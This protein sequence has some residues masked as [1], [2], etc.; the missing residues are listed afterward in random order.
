MNV[1]DIRIQVNAYRIDD[2]MERARVTLSRCQIPADIDT[3]QVRNIIQSLDSLFANLRMAYAKFKSYKAQVERLI[4]IVE[5]VNSTG[6]NESARR[7][8]ATNAC[9]NYVFN[10]QAVNLYELLATLEYVYD[11]LDGVLD[12]IR[13]RQERLITVTSVLKVEQNLLR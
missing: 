5:R 1:L 3:G 8:T 10:G 6:S 2:V 4:S 9:L 12:I 11:M 7:A 13:Q